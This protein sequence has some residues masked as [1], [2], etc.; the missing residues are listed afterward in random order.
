[1]TQAAIAGDPGAPR[2]ERAGLR[3]GQ[4]TFVW[5]ALIPIFL[6]L[7]VFALFPMIWVVVLS[8]FSYSPVRV[9]DG[10]LGLGGRNPFIGLENFTSMLADTQT[11]QL[12]RTSVKNTLIF[13]FLVLV[14]NL[15]ITLP[16]AVLVE[17]VHNRVK[18]V[19]RAIYFMP[20]ISSAVAVAIMWGYVFHPQQ[21]LLNNFI[22]LIGLTP[23]KSWLT[24][25]GAAVFGVP[26]A[27]VAVIIAYVWQDFGYNLVIFI[28]ALQGIPHDIRDA[29]Q[30]DGASGWQQFRRITVPLLRPT[31]LFVCTL[32]MISSFQV[33]VIFQVMTGGGPQN[34]T[35]SLTMDIYENAFR[36][37]AMGWAA[38][39][40]LILFAMV[41]IVTLVQ[42]RVLRTDWEY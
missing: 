35:R 29:A 1:M 15:A 39:M 28:A 5:G 21:G 36:Y 41:L 12:F 27:M 19:V 40:S 9:G 34:Q 4:R 26:L 16:L 13:A 42:F 30:I 20:T 37:Q 14:V 18:G 33:F 24:D 23:P 11:A 7:G 8:F 31:L 10:L 17:S 32:T 25:P 3:P 6:Y 2:K 22:K 38:A